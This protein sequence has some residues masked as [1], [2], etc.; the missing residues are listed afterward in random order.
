VLGALFVSVGIAREAHALNACTAAD[1]IAAEGANCPNST[2][3]CSIKRSYTIANGCILDFGTRTVT[4]S[5]PGGTLDVGSRGMTIKAGTFTVGSGG[6]VQ[7]LGNNPAPLDRG[8]MIMIQATGAVV[9]D[10]DG[11]DH[12][13]TSTATIAAA[14]GVAGELLA[15]L[16]LAQEDLTAPQRRGA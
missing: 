8:G 4:V 10:K 5:G 11:S 14:P 16:A 2:A 13:A 12:T 1:I 7:G 15:L 9:I 6:N 3:P